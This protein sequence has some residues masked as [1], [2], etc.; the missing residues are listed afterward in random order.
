VIFSSVKLTNFAVFFWGG[1]LCKIFNI[2]KLKKQTL[3]D[4]TLKT[5]LSWVFLASNTNG[6]MTKNVWLFWFAVELCGFLFC[7]GRSFFFTLLCEVSAVLGRI[8]NLQRK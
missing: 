8:A 3:G 2:T 7:R 4:H 1:N 6:Q 5:N